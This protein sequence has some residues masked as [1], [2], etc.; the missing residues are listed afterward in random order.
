MVIRGL[1]RVD[2]RFCRLKVLGA[3]S[4]VFI[5]TAVIAFTYLFALALSS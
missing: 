3:T 1:R 2:H 4:E 5:V